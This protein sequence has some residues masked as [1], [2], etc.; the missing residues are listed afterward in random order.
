MCEFMVSFF[1]ENFHLFVFDYEGPLLLHGLF[2]FLIVESRGHFLV[3]VHGLHIA[4]VSLSV[5]HGL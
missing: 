4:V 1:S 2:P 3:V 5:E